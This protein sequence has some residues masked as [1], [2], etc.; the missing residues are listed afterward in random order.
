L[1]SARL[2]SCHNLPKDGR[3]IHKLEIPGEAERQI[4]DRPKTIRLRP[5]IGVHLHPGSLFGIIPDSAF[6]FAGIS[7]P[8]GLLT[9]P[10]TDWSA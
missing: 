2:S 8:V 5:G 7:N 6:G 3:P 4:R 9:R 1:L 10:T